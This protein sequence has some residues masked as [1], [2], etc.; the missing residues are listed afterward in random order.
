MIP[1]NIKTPGVYI[2]EINGFPNSVVP[3]ATDDALRNPPAQ[4]CC[5]DSGPGNRSCHARVIAGRSPQGE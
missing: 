1:S 4:A 3:I 2:N 5:S